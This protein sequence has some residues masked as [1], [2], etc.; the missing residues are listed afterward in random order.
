MGGSGGLDGMTGVVEACCLSPTAEPNTCNHNLWSLNPSR[1][2]LKRYVH[3]RDHPTEGGFF[4]QG[5]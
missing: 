3:P 4:R 1:G 2:G 5:G